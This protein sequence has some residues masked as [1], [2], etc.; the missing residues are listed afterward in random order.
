M[1][2]KNIIT[3]KEV[4]DTAINESRLNFLRYLWESLLM[5]KI[6]SFDYL[7]RLKEINKKKPRNSVLVQRRRSLIRQQ[8][9][10]TESNTWI[11]KI[12]I[13]DLVKRFCENKNFEAIT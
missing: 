9:G 11:F 12:R 2:V 6:D 10:S 8:G 3:N 5:K 4:I 7:K 13:S 1:K